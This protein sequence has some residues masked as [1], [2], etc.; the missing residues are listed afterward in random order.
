MHVA[1]KIF[2]VLG[3]VITLAGVLMAVGGGAQVQSTIDE[4]DSFEFDVEEKSEFSGTEGVSD[5][6]MSPNKDLW[7]FVRDNVRCDEF[8][9]TMTNDTG[10]NHVFTDC[11]DDGEKPNG[12]DDDPKGWYH[13]ATISSWSYDEGE[14][15]IEANADYELVDSWVVLGEIVGELGE[16]ATGA[17]AALGGIMI[18]CCGLSFM[19]LGGIFALTLNSPKK[20]Q[21]NMAPLGASGFT[22][23]TNTV[24]EFTSVT[25]SKEDELKNWDENNS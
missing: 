11:E 22:T 23:S 3:V 18:A 7:V 25:P 2:L 5:Y 9:I 4:I 20:Q 15:T 14:Y 8:N 17:F 19:I 21:V 10:E 16:G 1:G 12:W 24:S 13:M 6:T